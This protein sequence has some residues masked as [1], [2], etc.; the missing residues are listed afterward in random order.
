MALLAVQTPVVAG[1]TPTYNAAALTNTFPNSGRVF[2][3]VK[4]GSGAS[5]NATLVATATVGGNAVANRV[6]AVP[7]GQER[8]I[9]PIDPNIYNAADGTCELD[10][11][12]ITT[13]T[14]GLY[15]LTN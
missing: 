1:I 4:N 9:G 11:S 15:Q 7:A 14:I 13:V 3:H 2:A 8:L 12:V 5:I 10:I 6:V